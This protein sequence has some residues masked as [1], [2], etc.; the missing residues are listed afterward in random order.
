MGLMSP[1]DALDRLL[2]EVSPVE[3]DRVDAAG[4]LGCVLAEAITADRDSPA[5]D[6]S[7][8]DGYAVR[9]AELGASSYPVAAEAWAGQAPPVVDAAGVAVRI[10]T[11][12][13]LP[14]GFDTVI[15]REAV[16]EGESA[17]EI[18][19]D[20]Q[21]PSPGDHVRLKGENVRAGREVVPASQRLTPASL[22]AAATFGRAELVVRRRVRVAVVNT[23]DE[24]EDVAGDPPPWRL[25]DGNGPFLRAWLHAQ[26]HVERLESRRVGDDLDQTAG[27]LADALGQ[28]DLVLTTGGVSMGDRDF[29]PEAF[30]RCGGRAVYHGLAMRPGKPNFAGVHPRGAVLMGLPG[31]PVSV[32]CAAVR[33]AAPVLR[34]LSGD[35]VV[36]PC[37]GLVAVEPEPGPGAKT[38]PLWWYRPFLRSADGAARLLETRGSGDVAALS[39]ADGF[40]E[41]PPGQEASSEPRRWWGWA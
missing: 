14:A 7:A 13:P 39:R 16:D 24:V 17:I 32:M 10:A 41:V 38:L 12:A 22:V 27:A 23:G 6:V 40:V 4:A 31:N 15:R 11:G 25:R 2:A 3:T 36:E 20:A 19:V 21:A 28:T 26:P 5:C 9:S 30:T 33:L 34:R 8:M 29:V 35:A 1:Q 18:K 37:A